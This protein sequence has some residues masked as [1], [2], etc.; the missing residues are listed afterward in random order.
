MAARSVIQAQAQCIEAGRAV[1]VVRAVSV[2]SL[3]AGE[4]ACVYR[5]L[6]RKPACGL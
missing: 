2:A 1:C 5:F 3:P 4:G 6:R